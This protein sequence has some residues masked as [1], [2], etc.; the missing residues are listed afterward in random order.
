M[1]HGT[2]VTE[3]HDIGTGIVSANTLD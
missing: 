2:R 1:L 3:H